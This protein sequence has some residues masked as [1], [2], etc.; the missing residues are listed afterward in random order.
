LLLELTWEALE[1]AGIAPSALAGTS[2]GVFGGMTGTE[3]ADQA[4]QGGILAHGHAFFAS[5]IA[6]SVAAGRLAYAFDLHG[7][8]VAVDTAC[9]SSLVATHMACQ[10]LRLRGGAT[11]LAAGVNLI[12]SPAGHILT[13]QARMTSFEGR[14][15]TFDASA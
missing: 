14:C 7:P 5:G 4:L 2:A 15:K 13:S 9:S 8:A 10:S 1:H 3:Y 6:R 11:A 12:L